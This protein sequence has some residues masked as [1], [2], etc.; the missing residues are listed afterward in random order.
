MRPGVGRNRMKDLSSHESTTALES[1]QAENSR[2]RLRLEE[3][4]ETLAAIRSGAIDAVVVEQDGVNRIYALESADRPYRLFVEEMHQGAATLH[5]D[6]T[7]A[8]CN[9]QLGILLRIPQPK[10]LGNFLRDY[11]LEADRSV[12]DEVLR[13]GR[14]QSGRSEAHLRRSDGAIVPTFLT[15]NALPDDCGSAIGVLVTDL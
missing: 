5:A 15:F 8:W 4:E 12:Y 11:V 7:I 1:L 3:A 13:E 9:R 10:L 14:R 2:L 6:G